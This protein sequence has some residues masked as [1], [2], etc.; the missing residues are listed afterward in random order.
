MWHSTLS[1]AWTCVTMPLCECVT[2]L[3]SCLSAFQDFA[4][5]EAVP[6]VALLRSIILKRSLFKP[7]PS[8][9]HSLAP[10][11]KNQRRLNF[12]GHQARIMRHIFKESDTN[13]GN[14]TATPVML[15]WWPWAAS[16]SSF[17]STHFL[18]SIRG[19]SHQCFST[20]GSTNPRG[21]WKQSF[22]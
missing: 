7:N 12:L 11:K 19:R 8:H 18:S 17:S 9:I 2:C 15:I 3:H 14:N 13:T 6:L 16:F 10:F 22:C 1:A 21:L 5:S 4:T 20:G